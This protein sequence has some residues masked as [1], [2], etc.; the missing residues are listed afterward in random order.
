MATS[1]TSDVISTAVPASESRINFHFR[2]QTAT[3]AGIIRYAT[4]TYSAGKLLVARTGDGVCAV[5]LD[6]DIT[7]LKDKLAQAFPRAELQ[8]NAEMLQSDI[9]KVIALIDTPEQAV[10][11]DID[12]GGTPFQRRVWNALCDIPRGETFSY[13]ELARQIGSPKAVRAVGSACGA[14][15]VAIAIPCHRALRSDGAISGYR[16]GPDRKRVLLELERDQSTWASR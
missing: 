2:D 7:Y 11:L 8:E 10:A 6:D 3:P 16:W 12:I 14:N 9:G 4:G 5:F 1:N 15:L 13:A